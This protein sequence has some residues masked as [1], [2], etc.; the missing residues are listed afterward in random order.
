MQTIPRL[1]TEHL[2]LREFTEVDCEPHSGFCS[3]AAQLE[4]N[5]PVSF[6]SADIYRHRS[7]QDFRRALNS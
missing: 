2:I 3:N 1:V 5:Q 6:F 7:P 4:S